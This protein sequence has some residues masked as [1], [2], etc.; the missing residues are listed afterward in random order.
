[1]RVFDLV[2]KLMQM[3]RDAEVL[4]PAAEFGA[5]SVTR[6]MAAPVEKVHEHSH[7]AVGAYTF[8][9]ELLKPEPEVKR[10]VAVL[11]SHRSLAEEVEGP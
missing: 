1:M 9:I 6:V 11:L 2:E 5:N 7:W 4:I 3:P 8:E 10:V